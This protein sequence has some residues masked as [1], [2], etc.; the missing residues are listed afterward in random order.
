MMEAVFYSQQQRI[1]PKHKVIIT[2]ILTEHLLRDN[3]VRLCHGCKTLGRLSSSLG[4]PQPLVLVGDYH[5]K[6]PNAGGGTVAN[7]SNSLIVLN[8]GRKTI[9]ENINRLHGSK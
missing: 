7:R 4:G 6:S 9:H 8:K 2:P 5:Q 3:V 1:I